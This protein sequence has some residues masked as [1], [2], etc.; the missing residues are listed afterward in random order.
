MKTARERANEI[1]R[2][3]WFD[4]G[5]EWRVERIIPMIEQQ[6]AEA[7]EKEL[8][9]PGPQPDFSPGDVISAEKDGTIVL[10]DGITTWNP[11][12]ACEF[13]LQAETAKLQAEIAELRAGAA[14]R[15]GASQ[16][17]GQ[18][19]DGNPPANVGSAGTEG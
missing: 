7:R 12:R 18:S 5:G 17:E 8:K 6:D 2:A 10:D 13:L 4:I 3:G 19:F 16:G 11:T 15:V 1:Q 14:A 9:A